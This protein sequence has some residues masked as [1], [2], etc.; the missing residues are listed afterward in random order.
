M[1]TFISRFYFG[2]TVPER[3]IEVV[4]FDFGGTLAYNEP[5]ADIM[6]SSV[7]RKFGIARSPSEIRIV[8]EKIA[9][10]MGGLP[11]Q[12]P[13]AEKQFWRQYDM[14]VAQH[15]GYSL[16]PG[17]SDALSHAFRYEVNTILYP[18]VIPTLEALK[19]KGVRL[20]IISNANF[21]LLERLDA[22]SLTKRFHSIT[23]SATVGANKP[24]RRIFQAALDSLHVPA[25]AAVHIG[26]SYEAD[27]LGAKAAG[28]LAIWLDRK[29]EGGRAGLKVASLLDLLPLIA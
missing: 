23:C 9:S 3:R 24:D 29:N 11:P 20:G 8:T 1:P 5:D 10:Q 16:E 25:T 15:L 21:E 4:F 2:I 28:L 7:L 27:F 17:L 14:E 26:D 19:Q 18:D 13:E 12:S 6:Y 22:L